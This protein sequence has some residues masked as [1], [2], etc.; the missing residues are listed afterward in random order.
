MCLTHL[1][2]ES[3]TIGK[4]LNITFPQRLMSVSSQVALITGASSGLGVHFARELARRNWDLVITAR[5]QSRLLRLQKE[6]QDAHDV[7]VHPIALDLS[8][9]DGA[10]QLFDEVESLQYNV[11][12]LVNNAGVGHYGPM[13]DQ[14]LES[15]DN[16][17]QLNLASLTT[18][19]RLFADRMKATGG[20]HILQNASFSGFTPVPRYAVYAATKSYVL[21]LAQ[22]MRYELHRH[23]VNVSVLC[24]GFA[25]SGFFETAGHEPTRWMRMMTLDPAKVAHSG[26]KGLFRGRAVIVPGLLYKAYA[27]ALRMMPRSMA[28]ALAAGVIKSQTLSQTLSPSQSQMQDDGSLLVA[29]PHDGDV[30]EEDQPVQV[31]EFGETQRAG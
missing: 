7:Q 1:R 23:H 4:L 18:L 31:S 22:A 9:R 24:P 16:M 5:R 2:R 20:G 3:L 15:I 29:R 26:I 30:V 10:R 27:L 12:V 28:C 13:V 14:P 8:G 19:T 6:L 21:S 25:Q 17:I 11:R